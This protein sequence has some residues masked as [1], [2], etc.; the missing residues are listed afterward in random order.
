MRF[1]W[2]C[3]TS[4]KRKTR[5][6]HQWFQPFCFLQ[7]TSSKVARCAVSGEQQENLFM[8]PHSS[9][10]GRISADGRFVVFT[11]QASNLVAG[12][13]AHVRHIFI[14]DRL[15]GLTERTRLN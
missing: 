8:L 10:L 13:A 15:K 4:E 1:P 5:A 9:A 7:P 12:D 14:R 3:E 11:S 6:R 2:I